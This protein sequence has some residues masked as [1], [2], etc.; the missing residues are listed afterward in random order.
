MK[1]IL[2]LSTIRERPDVQEKDYLYQDK[3]YKGKYTNDAPILYLLDQYEVSEIIVILTEQAKNTALQN[4]KKVVAS[5]NKTPKITEIDYDINNDFKD[6]TLK[7][8]LNNID[9]DD[10]ILL[11]TTGGIRHD[12]THLLLISQILTYKD[13]PVKSVIYSNFQN[14]K[15][16]KLDDT[17]NLFKIITAMEVFTT[18]GNI[19][20]L[21]KNYI[22]PY[23]DE[24]IESVILALENLYNVISLCFAEKITDALNILNIALSN[25]KDTDDLLFSQL[26]AV[27]E[28][29]YGSKMDLIDLISWCIDSSMIQQAL[30]IYNELLP[31]YLFENKF[32]VYNGIYKENK[33]DLTDKDFDYFNKIFFKSGEDFNQ[34]Q[35]FREML[36]SPDIK[37]KIVNYITELDKYSM[38][39]ELPEFID[40]LDKIKEIS[41]VFYPYNNET[42]TK[43]SRLKDK[44]SQ[45]VFAEVCKKS[46]V[47][48]ATQLRGSSFNFHSE[49]VVVALS[50]LKNE[51]LSKL[52]SEEVQNTNVLTIENLSEINKNKSRY[53]I[54]LNC[55][56]EQF[57]SICRDYLYIKSLRNRTNHANSDS[58]S[59][60][61]ITNYLGGF[62]YK[63][64]KEIKTVTDTLEILKKAIQNVRDAKESIKI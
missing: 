14:Y 19:S 59:E 24:K 16:E 57:K 9:K 8:I 20:V 3:S 17:V 29:K 11:D 32:I 27:F 51:L 54:D 6:I 48:V 61:V 28:N 1:V 13:I 31:K 12:V 45:E 22:K 53:N 5:T 21:R 34:I 46:T 60:E 43:K 39:K 33:N 50:G 18:T 40:A 10:E 56:I 55:D 30:T 38:K 49:K 25:C 58:K 47:H 2:F 63:D 35:K 62:S 44:V 42:I 36:L 41:K 52:L 26:I 64:I 23:K 4:F 15:I 37:S 7:N